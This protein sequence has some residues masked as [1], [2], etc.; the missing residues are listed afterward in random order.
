MLEIKTIT[1]TSTNITTNC[2]TVIINGV[3]K[4]LV[5]TIMKS[6]NNF[7]TTKS[8]MEE[9]RN[10]IVA[11]MIPSHKNIL[12]TSLLLAPNPLK[13][14]ISFVLSKTEI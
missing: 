5:P 8:P 7:V 9:I 4:I 11:S 3:N 12:V 2:L 14:P 1:Y 13:I 10:A 6:F